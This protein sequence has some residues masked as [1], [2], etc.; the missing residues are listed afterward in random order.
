MSKV[1]ID[2][3]LIREPRGLKAARCLRFSHPVGSVSVEFAL[4]RASGAWVISHIETGRAVCE[5]DG[6]IA[7]DA[8]QKLTVARGL[9]DDTLAMV[10]GP[11]GFFRAV[12]NARQQENALAGSTGDAEASG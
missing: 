11:E 3:F 2:R 12:E 1:L 7:G 10:G 4:H 9:I 6:P 8:P 5:I